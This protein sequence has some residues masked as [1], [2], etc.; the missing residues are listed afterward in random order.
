MPSSKDQM[1]R[2]LNRYRGGDASVERE[3]LDGIYSELRALAAAHMK[4]QPARHTLQ[5]TALVSEAWLRLARQEDL[6]FDARG[7]FYRL[8][9]ATMRSVL[10]DHARRATSGKRG[11]ANQRASL[12]AQPG[13]SGDLPRVVEILTLEESLRRLEEIKPELCRIVELRFFGG[14]SNPEVAETLGAPLRT[15]ERRWRAARAW[16]HAELSK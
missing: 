4:G 15:I 3:L 13:Q 7:Q 16:L 1:T 11:G 2:L 12:E 9:S 5:P 10:V 8:A 14:L 6:H